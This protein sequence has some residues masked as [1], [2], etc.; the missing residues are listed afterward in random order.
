MDDVLTSSDIFIQ[1]LGNGFYI[2]AGTALV[3][4]L[5]QDYDDAH[6]VTKPIDYLLIGVF[7]FFSGLLFMFDNPIIDISDKF[8]FKDNL[9]TCWYILIFG[10]LLS[11]YVKFR[12]L[13]YQQFKMTLPE[14]IKKH[15]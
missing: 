8:S 15:I 1:L 10:M 4:S 13:W 2:F 7:V 11:G 5:F 14:F 9:S 3:V 12:I 6:V